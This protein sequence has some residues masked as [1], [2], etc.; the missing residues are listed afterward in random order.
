MKLNIKNL[1][2]KGKLYGFVGLALVMVFSLIGTGIYYYGNIEDA[3]LKKEDFNRVIKMMQDTRIAEKNYLQFQHT[4]LKTEFD[5]RAD[6]LKTQ[7]QEIASYSGD[8]QLAKQINASGELFEKYRS[9]FT[10]LINTKSKHLQLKKDMLQPLRN[11]EAMLNSILGKLEAKQAEL[12]MEG[13]V[14]SRDEM[15]MMNVARDCKIVFLK[16]QN[17]QYQYLNTGDEQFLEEFR[18]IATNEATDQI[19]ALGQFAA[20]LNNEEFINQSA[21]V[22]ESSRQFLD[23]IQASQTLSDA[24]RNLTAQIDKSGQGVIE[25]LE[26]L[27]KITNQFIADKRASAVRAITLI[28]AIGISAFVILS[29]FIVRLI[30][31]PLGYVLASLK[32]IA[33][34]EGDLTVRLEAKTRDELGQLSHWFNVFVEK[35]QSI[36]RDVAQS[37]RQL[38]NSSGDL[39]KIAEQMSNNAEQTSGK[40]NTVADSGKGMSANMS[41]V[42]AAMGEASKNINM[43]AEA[44]EGMTATIDE[45]AGNTEKAHSITNDAVSQAQNASDRIGELGHAAQDIGKVV[46][47]ITEISEQVNLLA[48]N[49]TIEAARAGEAG[50]GFAVVANEIKELARQTAEATGEIKGQVDGIQASTEGTIGEISSI[51]KI[52]NQVNGIVSTIAAAI[53]EQSVTTKEIAGNV[54]QASHGIGEINTNVAQSSEMANEIA[55]EIVDVNQAA[56]E[57]SN[58]SAQVKQNSEGVSKLAGELGE[59]VSRFKV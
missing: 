54:A 28:V 14:L 19:T 22:G 9:L 16:L 52:V 5:S 31:R 17:L 23:S 6:K 24:E 40:A 45:I 4:E 46:E 36:I 58:S 47:A 42:V 8:E 12:Q 43:V 26:S 32:D 39:L 10:D 2:I 25:N 7:I 15:E 27:L 57:M 37:A 11:A 56:V 44:A 18:D 20:S 51:S 21:Q 53:E 50:K 1:S 48:L 34:G 41:S 30:T 55:N 3:N 33:E 38:S 29:V 35:I 13:D 49:A 59:L